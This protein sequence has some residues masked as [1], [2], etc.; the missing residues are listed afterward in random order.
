MASERTP[1]MSVE[2]YFELEE[3]NPDTRYEYLD[4]YVYMMS[5]G[6]ANHATISGNIYAILKSFLR[7][8]PCRVYNSD[9]KVRVSEKR[10]FHPDVTVTCDPRDRGTADLIQ[11]PR[12]V[13]EVLSPSTEA[14]DRGR[15]LQCYLACPSIEE[16]LLVDTRSMRIEIYRK[17]QKKWVYDAFEA[18]DEVELI[19][20]SVL[21][22]VTDAYEDVIF[23][24]DE[25]A[26][27]LGK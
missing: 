2:E 20:L 9:M 3:N 5:G 18:G 12:L 16:Y 26:K 6:S 1:T 25:N 7:G 14:R 21:F 8:G 10:Y 4:G 19:T 15:K 24:K 17:E 13:I 11:S 27:H 23:A 22:P